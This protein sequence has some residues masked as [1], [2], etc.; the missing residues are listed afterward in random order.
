M[1]RK[2]IQK[3]MYKNYLKSKPYCKDGREF[4]GTSGSVHK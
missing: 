1:G 4:Q 3:D 2:L